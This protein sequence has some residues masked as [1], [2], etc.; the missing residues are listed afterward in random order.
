[1]ATKAD[2]V[3]RVATA[4]MAN[5]AAMAANVKGAGM[6]AMAAGIVTI[7]TAT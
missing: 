7:D 2:T 6:V 3:R 4:A 1:M 5:G